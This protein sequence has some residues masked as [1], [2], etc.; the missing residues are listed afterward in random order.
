MNKPDTLSPAFDKTGAFAISV[1]AGVKI[2]GTTY[3]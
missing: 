3:A 1:K 2:A